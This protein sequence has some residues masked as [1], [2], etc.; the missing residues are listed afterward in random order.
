MQIDIKLMVARVS[1]VKEIGGWVCGALSPT[2]GP[3]DSVLIAA[4]AT[5]P[6][7]TQVAAISEEDALVDF[8]NL[9]PQDIHQIVEFIRLYGL[10]S[11]G[12]VV[13]MAGHPDDVKAYWKKAKQLG[14]TPFAT[15]LAPFRDYRERVGTMLKLARSR[16]KR[17]RDAA[18]Q[19]FLKIN[20]GLGELMRR[21]HPQ[22]FEK[23]LL[24]YYVSQGLASVALGVAPHRRKMVAVALAPDVRSALYVALLS[25]I[26]SGTKLMTCART[27]CTNLFVVARSDKRFCTTRCQNLAKVKRY[28]KR[29]K[30]KRGKK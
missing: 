3:P 9:N 14:R 11:F 5:R 15:N 10:F 13:G 25:S 22:D 4:Q 19:E 26:V 2:S 20:R 23:Q 17:E 29:R 12:D 1:D 8:V 27:G 6:W 18:F 28:R 16:G 24:S 7:I 21:T 30:R